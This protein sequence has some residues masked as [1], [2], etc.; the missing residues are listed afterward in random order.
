MQHKH[1]LTRVLLENL[2]GGNVGIA[3]KDPHQPGELHCRRH[4]RARG[5][6]RTAACPHAG[7]SVRAGRNRTFLR[8]A[9]PVEP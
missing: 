3:E 1:R 4:P 7:R 2:K 6:R 5:D 8:F 9:V